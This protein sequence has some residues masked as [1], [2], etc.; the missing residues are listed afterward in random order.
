MKQVIVLAIAIFAFAA[1]AKVAKKPVRYYV[2][3]TNC[4]VRILGTNCWVR[5]MHDNFENTN[6]VIYCEPF[7]PPPPPPPAT[8]TN[9]VENVEAKVSE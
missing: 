1:F 5:Y 9:D 6:L 7:D 8:Q 3:P 2:Y 4:V